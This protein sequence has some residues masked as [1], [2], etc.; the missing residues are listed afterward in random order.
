[1]KCVDRSQ[2][3]DTLNVAS[4]CPVVLWRRP[5]RFV[6]GCICIAPTSLGAVGAMEQQPP[7]K[8][9]CTTP[10]HDEAAGRWWLR[11][12]ECVPSLKPRKFTL[13]AL[14]TRAL[15]LRSA[16]PL[17]YVA[18]SLSLRNVCRNHTRV[19]AFRQSRF[20]GGGHLGLCMCLT[21][22]DQIFIE[23]GGG[24]W[25]WGSKGRTPPKNN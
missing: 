22:R 19:A 2:G 21:V 5:N 18:A 25:L 10:Q 4:C 16:G 14:C 13:D 8:P 17:R 15:W 1:M 24:N 9:N 7:Y 23:R 6:L 20:V 11:R 12:W 3:A